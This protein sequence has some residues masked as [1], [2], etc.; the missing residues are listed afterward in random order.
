MGNSM[1]IKCL[2]GFVLFGA[3]TYAQEPRKTTTPDLAG[4]WSGTWQSDTSPHH[5]PMKA[6]FQSSGEGAY[7][8]TFTGRFFKV[9]P[10]RYTAQLHVTGAE[11]DK[12]ILEGSQR[13]IGFGTFHYHAKA[14]GNSFHAMYTARRD[15][16]QFILDRV[17]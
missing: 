13:L 3:L 4:N 1:I 8:V 15:Q 5:G 12:V 16:G 7:Q 6:H 2:A 9:F 17:R 10:F 14:D 11:G